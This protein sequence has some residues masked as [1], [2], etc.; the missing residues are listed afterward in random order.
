MTHEIL[1]HK[2]IPMP[3]VMQILD[4]K[5]SSGQGME[6]ARDDPSMKFGNSQEQKGGYSGSTKRQKRKSNLQH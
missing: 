6:K 4:A 2:F 1:V 3:Q 5:G